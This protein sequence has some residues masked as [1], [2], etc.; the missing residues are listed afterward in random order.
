M[1]NHLIIGL[2]GTGGKILREM[3]KRIYEEFRSNDPAGKI[4]IEYLYIDSS[5]EDLNS[6]E[7]WKTMGTSVHLMPSQKLSI[8]GI[9]S[10]VLSNLHQYPGIQ[11]FINPT[12]LTLLDDIGALI[13]DGIGGQR[14]RLGRLL[15]ANNLSGPV[16]K[17]FTTLLRASVD[18]LTEKSKENKVSFHI[19]AGLAGGTGSGSIIDAIAQIQQIYG[20]QGGMS[21]HNE[22]MLYL[23]VPEMIVANPGHDAGYYQANGFAALRELNGMSVNYYKPTDVSGKKINENG[24][25][26]R[27][28]DHCD[29]FD[30]AY[31]FSNV[32]EH[33]H[34]VNIGTDLPAVVSDF[35]FQKI[36]AA[37]VGTNGQMARLMKCENNGTEPE[38]NRA[39][40]PAYS[41]K[42]MTFG[43]TRVEYP[44]TEVEEYVTYSFEK[45]AA[46]QM[47]YNLWRDGIGYDECSIEEIGVGY[48]GQ[49]NDK[50]DKTLDN[51]KLTNRYLTLSNPIIESPG[52]SRWKDITAG[53]E[54]C[55]QFFAD[56]AQSSNDKKSW[57]SLFTKDC[58]LQ[59]QEN[60]RG[61]GVKKF[62]EAQR[63]EKK[64][65]AAYIRRIIEESLFN[66]WQNGDKSIL[67]VEK[68]ITA[69][70]TVCEERIPKM[71][72]Q[73]V[74]YGN[75]IEEQVNPEISRCNNEWDNI[76]WLR[77]AI[78]NAS[79]KVFSAY[80][81]AKCDLYTHLTRIEGLRYAVE[82]MQAI[83]FE[84]S[85]LQNNVKDLSAV[86]LQ[87]T[88]RI[89][90][91]TESKCKTTED[92]KDGAKIIKKYDPKLVRSTTKVFT[93]DQEKQKENARD[94]RNAMVGLLGED[95]PRSFSLL[96]EKADI[97]ILEDIFDKECGKNASAMMDNLAKTDATQKMRDVNILEKIKKEYNSD[98]TLEDF[99]G[100][101][102]KSAQCYL[103][104]NDE[105]IAKVI[106]GNENKMMRMIQLC[107]PEYNDPSNFR[108]KF[109]KKFAEMCPGGS[110][111]PNDCLSTNY[112]PNQIVVV[113][114]ASGF[115]LRFVANVAVL[116]NK[117]EEKLIG[118][119]AAHNKMVLHTETF[120]EDLPSLFEKS[121]DEKKKELIPTVLMAYAMGIVT[122]K[123]EQSTGMSFKAIGFA[124]VFGNISN[125][126][127]LGKN[128]LQT[129]D[130][131][132]TKD[133]DAQKV[134]ALVNDKFTNEYL[135]VAKKEELKMALG[136]T[137]NNEVLPLC[138]GDDLNPQYK[139]YLAAA[140]K[141]VETKLT[142]Q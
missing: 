74:K 4:E 114:A 122:D 129:V 139:E 59:Y 62:Y 103:Q 71:Q 131:L 125:W 7:G 113:A 93:V 132:A 124:D 63:G 24:E 52:T 116:K 141:L 61:A 53:W 100:G 15:F 45:Q 3:R 60:Y 16:D 6:K 67:Q 142:V 112:K 44:E 73:I 135:H 105:E 66:E 120:R 58:E 51:F 13:A 26:K 110:F 108:D 33:G 65:Y 32:N 78:T 46:R 82:L 27:L 28:L 10:N 80:K 91:K 97:N 2:G 98:E 70:I 84:L 96:S 77:D 42:F 56:S 106:P 19:C 69:L 29:A 123:T 89:E 41:R 5:E 40:Q 107:L 101:L 48:K 138:G 81:N 31:L 21:N 57:L 118:Q 90:D 8:H 18:K 126:L 119:R 94:V 34:K 30:A 83:I 109:I 54:S 38:S 72:E 86:I 39:G 128:I 92:G 75:Y 11:S 127:N 76:G 64:G 79:V 35:L 14:R 133:A 95:A 121:A 43:V 104:F 55:T 85:S 102:V 23:Y 22:L 37:N 47:Q 88:K 137:V 17:S 36:I 50:H 20:P 25:V 68:F 9:G 99:I 140:L 49:L 115:P 1:A 12:D 87:L 136:K 134:I 130:V 111:N 117:Y